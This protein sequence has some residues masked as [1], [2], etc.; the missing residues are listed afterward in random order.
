MWHIKN[1]ND[2]IDC[3]DYKLELHTDLWSLLKSNGVVNR[4]VWCIPNT[5]FWYVALDGEIKPTV[6]TE[7]IHSNGAGGGGLMVNI[8]IFNW[9]VKRWAIFEERLKL[10]RVKRIWDFT[11]PTAHATNGFTSLTIP[12]LFNHPIPR[13]CSLIKRKRISFWKM[14]PIIVWQSLS[15]SERILFFFYTPFQLVQNVIQNRGRNY[16]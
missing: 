11:V 15:R 14:K 10:N 2:C 7:S 13:A 9:S 1:K 4:R 5:S 16:F 3:I 8:I 6:L 12:L